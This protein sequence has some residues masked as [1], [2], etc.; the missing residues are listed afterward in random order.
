MP[1]GGV[2]AG[3]APGG[4]G[5]EIGLRVGDRVL[6]V[7]G[8]PLR[9]ALDFQFYGAHEDVVLS[10]WREGETIL[11]RGRR[12]YDQ[13]WGVAFEQALFDGLRACAN[14]CPFCFLKGL[15]DGLRPS[16]YVRDDD[17]RLSF[18]H[19]S[20]VTL[21]NLDEADWERLAEQRLSPL[22]VS[23]HATDPDLRRRLLGTR[24]SPDVRQQLRRLGD[25]GIRVHAQVV[26][27]PGWNDGEALSRTIAD[28]WELRD[29]VES[30][31]LVPVGLSAH[32]PV[33]LERVTP[34]G[35]RDLLRLADDWRHRAYREVGR[36]FVHPSDELYLLAGRPLPGAQTYD[37]FPQLQNGVGLVRQFVEDWAR[38]RRRLVRRHSVRTPGRHVTL[39]TGMAFLPFLEQV[40]R[41]LG[42]MLGTS[43]QAVGVANRFLGQPVTVAGLLTARDVVE[44]LS[45]KELGDVVVLPRSMLDAA[46]EHTLDDWSLAELGRALGRPVVTASLASEVVGVWL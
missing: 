8:H 41:D 14:H 23:V 32:H 6:A 45:G 11:R 44:Q 34:S 28:L 4:F 9:D 25:L 20:F 29:V 37:G 5:A 39:V 16:L 40:A 22:Y 35:A 1:D 38:T 2:I 17:Y 13:P 12:R 30:V 21:T 27:C 24:S 7:N 46:G 43:C 15:P 3:L 10:I 18:L 19:G 42:S 31:S 26:V 33:R 36:R